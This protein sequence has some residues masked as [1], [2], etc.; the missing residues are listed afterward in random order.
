MR[1]ITKIYLYECDY[2]EHPMVGCDEAIEIYIGDA[3]PKYE[4][5]LFPHLAGRVHSVDDA[6]R[7]AR[8]HYK[9]SIGKHAH[10]CPEHHPRNNRG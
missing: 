9:W 8:L 7:V 6:D 5:A 1:S 3:I 10:F 2:S 4:G